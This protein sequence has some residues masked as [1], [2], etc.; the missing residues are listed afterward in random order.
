MSESERS[1]SGA[2]HDRDGAG[3]ELERE[4]TV[5]NGAWSGVGAR[6]DRMERSWSG[7]PLNLSELELSWSEKQSERPIS[8]TKASK[9]QLSFY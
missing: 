9:T 5:W 6:Y 8:A 3:A 7:A 1:R 2:L 4:V